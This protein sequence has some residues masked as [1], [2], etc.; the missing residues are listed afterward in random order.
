[1]LFSR[2]I[3]LVKELHPSTSSHPPFNPQETLPS[4]T[5][6]SATIY[7]SMFLQSHLIFLPQPNSTNVRVKIKVHFSYHLSVWF[8]QTVNCCLVIKV[9]DSPRCTEM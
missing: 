6:L 3:S 4:V 8:L 7:P 1:M 9:T 5:S 2:Y